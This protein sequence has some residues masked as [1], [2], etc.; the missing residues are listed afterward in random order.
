MT[1]FVSTD[2]TR[3]PPHLPVQMKERGETTNILSLSLSLLH[4]YISLSLS[5]FAVNERRAKNVTW[6]PS[7]SPIFSHPTVDHTDW[8]LWEKAGRREGGGWVEKCIITIS[9]SH[10]QR[11]LFFSLSLRL[12]SYIDYFNSVSTPASIIFSPRCTQR[13]E[14]LPPAITLPLQQHMSPLSVTSGFIKQLFEWERGRK[15]WL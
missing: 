12:S 14:Y 6:S 9:S 3:P 4:Y 13:R 8:Q 15:T 7:S 2:R 5:A 11:F 10:S 1:A